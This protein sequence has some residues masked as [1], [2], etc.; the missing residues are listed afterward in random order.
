MNPQIFLVDVEKK[1]VPKRKVLKQVPKRKNQN[2][3]L[4]E[5]QKRKALKNNN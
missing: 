2:D 4:K 1:Q 5:D 3:Y